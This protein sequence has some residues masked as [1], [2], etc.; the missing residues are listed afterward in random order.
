MVVLAVQG[1]RVYPLLLQEVH[2]V[3]VEALDLHLNPE[4]QEGTAQFV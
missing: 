3:A 4:L 1:R 2:M